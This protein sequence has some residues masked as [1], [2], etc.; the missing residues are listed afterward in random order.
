MQLNKILKVMVHCTPHTHVTS[1]KN[2]NCYRM[3][4]GHV[5]PYVHDFVKKYVYEENKLNSIC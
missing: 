4:K 3:F 2:I 5:C 1:I